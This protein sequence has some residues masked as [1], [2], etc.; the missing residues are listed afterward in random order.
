VLEAKMGMDAITLKR[1]ATFTGKLLL[2]H[3]RLP[4]FSKS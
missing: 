2:R 1:D 4:H 3:L